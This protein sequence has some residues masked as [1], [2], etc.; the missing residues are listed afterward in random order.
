MTA[1]QIAATLGGAR[2]SS[3]WWRCRC[4]VHQSHGATL[5]L[6]DGDLGLIVKCFAGCDPRGVLAELHRR[7]L[8]RDG[9]PYFSLA[10]ATH[11]PAVTGD[12]VAARIAA[13][14]RLWNTARDAQ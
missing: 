10:E 3:G 14:R 8:T 13:A 11:R 12:N 2:R 6:R 5:A 4:P 7:R 9:D 1:E